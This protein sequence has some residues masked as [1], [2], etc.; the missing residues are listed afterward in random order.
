V[1]RAR[2]EAS[3]APDGYNIGM[4]VGAAPG[5]T[6]FHL[7]VHVIPA[8]RATSPTPPAVSASPCPA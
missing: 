6:V 1:A 2:I 7:H 8:T 3:H 4:N 5:Q